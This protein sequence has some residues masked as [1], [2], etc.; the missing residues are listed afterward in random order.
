MDL[1]GCLVSPLTLRAL[2]TTLVDRLSVTE[3][4]NQPTSHEKVSRAADL[5]PLSI[6]NAAVAACSSVHRITTG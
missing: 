1:V 6:L 5:V 4:T 3:F 2:P